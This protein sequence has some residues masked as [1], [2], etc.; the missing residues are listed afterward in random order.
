MNM[1]TALYLTR[2]SLIR[3]SRTYEAIEAIRK[4]MDWPE[5][6]II[7]GLQQVALKTNGR[8]NPTDDLVLEMP[9]G[10]LI[11]TPIDLARW[12]DLKGLTPL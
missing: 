10:E 4:W 3:S 11:R 7:V 9:D 1:K 6:E 5:P 2:A 8:F 12:I